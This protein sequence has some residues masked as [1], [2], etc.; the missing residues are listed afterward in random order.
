MHSCKSAQPQFT[1]SPP[2]RLLVTTAGGF[3]TIQPECHC[4]ASRARMQPCR[5]AVVEI[6]HYL[7]LLHPNASESAIWLR[8][9]NG[10]T[11]ML[12]RPGHCRQYQ[13][14][15]MFLHCSLQPQSS[16]TRPAPMHCRFEGL[17][18]STSGEAHDPDLNMFCSELASPVVHIR[19][20]PPRLETP[21]CFLLCL[22]TGSTSL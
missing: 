15:P 19:I 5:Q 9:Q 21:S 2:P 6:S 18:C 8:T 4:R 16:P 1:C 10:L 7:T 3:P 11:G 13:T 14:A 20:A 12:H 22:L 17:A